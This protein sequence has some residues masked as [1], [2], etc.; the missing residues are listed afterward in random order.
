[1]CSFLSTDYKRSL[2]SW[3]HPNS[4]I[5]KVNEIKMSYMDL[6]PLEDFLLVFKIKCSVMSVNIGSCIYKAIIFRSHLLLGY[7]VNIQK[8]TSKWKSSVFSGKYDKVCLAITSILKPWWEK[9]YA[10]KLKLIESGVVQNP[11]GT[12]AD[13]SL[14]CLTIS[15]STHSASLFLTSSLKCLTVILPLLFPFSVFIFSCFSFFFF[16]VIWLS[17]SSSILQAVDQL[18]GMLRVPRTMWSSC[19][20]P[21]LQWGLSVLLCPDPS[22]MFISDL[23]EV[24]NSSILTGRHLSI[25]SRAELPERYREAG[26]W[27][28][29]TG[30]LLNEDLTDSRLHTSPAAQRAKASSTVWTGVEAE[31]WGKRTSPSAQHSLDHIWVQQPL[32]GSQYRQVID[33]LEQVSTVLLRWSGIEALL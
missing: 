14:F 3:A 15:W 11:L 21:H 23:E 28:G 2:K 10:L 26:W 33:K 22:N 20:P 12:V 27:N 16:L 19:V 8:V 9:N 31:N 4:D 29:L 30:A 13:F 7:F 32:L 25:Y 6:R 18:Q 17:G 24:M 5:Y 1:M